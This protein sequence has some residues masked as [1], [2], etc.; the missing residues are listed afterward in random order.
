MHDF[1]LAQGAI[2][3]ADH[4]DFGESPADYPAL[5]QQTVVSLLDSQGL[6]EVSGGQSGKCLQGQLTCD[7]LSLD[8]QHVVAGAYCTP[9]GRMISNFLLSSPG[10]EHFLLRMTRPCVKATADTLSKYSPF[11]KCSISDCS[12]QFTLFGISGPQA[13]KTVENIFAALPPQRYDCIQGEG[14]TLVCIEENRR[15]ECWIANDA[16][17]TLGTKL[18]ANT[19]K[20]GEAFWQLQNI[21]QGIGEVQASTIEEWIP[22]MLNLQALGAINFRKG[23]YTGQEIVARTQYRGQHKRTMFRLA[24]S[25]SS[26]PLAGDPVTQEGKNI[27]EVVQASFCEANRF[28][29]LAVL[30][31]GALENAQPLLVG[32]SPIELL[33]LPYSIELPEK[34]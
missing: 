21:R 2:A 23:C 9:K 11:F 26:L 10:S 13:A 4:L 30:N 32:D 3:K 8:A 5:S 16:L 17:E 19:A 18:F 24:G 27:G 34:S 31:R 33:S 22:Q 6:L 25:G 28:E 20:S 1:L 29:L 12:E 14:Y 15:Y 7:V